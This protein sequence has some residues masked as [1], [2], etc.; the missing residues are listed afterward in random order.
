MRLGTI[1]GI[2]LASVALVAC[3]GSDLEAALVTMA[4]RVSNVQCEPPRVTLRQLDDELEDAGISARNERCAWDGTLSPAVC[5]AETTIL[6]VIDLPMD[7]E[8]DA[9]ALDYRA[10]T[11]FYMFIESDCPPR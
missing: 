1:A 7:Q 11:E 8:Q 5:G 10:A 9:R 3:G 2:A 4:K 6:R